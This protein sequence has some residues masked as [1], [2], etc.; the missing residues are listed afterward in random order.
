MH[1]FQHYIFQLQSIDVFKDNHKKIINITKRL[2][3]LLIW[4]TCLALILKHEHVHFEMFEFTFV[5]PT[6]QETARVQSKMIDLNMFN[7]IFHISHLTPTEAA[8]LFRFRFKLIG[9]FYFINLLVSFFCSSIRWRQRQ[10]PCRFVHLKTRNWCLWSM[11]L[12]IA[13]SASK[14]PI[15]ICMFTMCLKW[16][17][18]PS[19]ACVEDRSQTIIWQISLLN[20]FDVPPPCSVE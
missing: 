8:T 10:N 7:D 2:C 6:V 18:I 1:F 3:A 14:H 17:I 20:T 11:G 13:C 9:S 5:G 16:P 19:E 15:F 12:F 4:R